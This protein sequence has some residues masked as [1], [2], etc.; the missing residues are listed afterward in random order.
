MAPPA[1]IFIRRAVLPAAWSATVSET[2]KSRRLDPN[3]V[4]AIESLTKELQ[5]VDH[6]VHELEVRA[7]RGTRRK[8]QG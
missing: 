3:L 7:P 6:R 8:S 5:P 1:G 4:E 2:T